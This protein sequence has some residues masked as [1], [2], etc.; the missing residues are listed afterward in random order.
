M[1]QE[2]W[3]MVDE[4]LFKLKKDIYKKT[5]DCLKNK[6]T[7]GYQRKLKFYLKEEI[8]QKKI[9]PWLNS[10]QIEPIQGILYINSIVILYD[11][12]IAVYFGENWKKNNQEI[13][14]LQEEDWINRTIFTQEKTRKRQFQN[15][16]TLCNKKR[17]EI[18]LFPAFSFGNNELLY[19]H[20]KIKNF[21][22]PD[23]FLTSPG[24]LWKN[25]NNIFIRQENLFD[26]MKKFKK[27]FEKNYQI[28]IKS[29]KYAE[30]L[31]LNP[32]R[33]ATKYK[34]PNLFYIYDNRNINEPGGIAFVARFKDNLGKT[35]IHKILKKL[36]YYICDFILTPILIAESEF[37]QQ[38]LKE[39]SGEIPYARRFFREIVDEKKM[40][41]RIPLVYNIKN[42][43]I[44]SDPFGN[45]AK[46]IRKHLNKFFA[47][48][49]GP[50]GKAMRDYR[51]FSEE[52]FLTTIKLWD[53]LNI[54]NELVGHYPTNNIKTMPIKTI[55]QFKKLSGER[56]NNPLL[57]DILYTA[58]NFE[59]ALKYISSYRE[60][61]IHCF[62]TFCFGFWLLCLKRLNGK[63]LFAPDFPERL[64]LLKSWFLTAIFH[65]IGIP[66]QKAGNYLQTL[67]EKLAYQKDLPLFSKWSKLMDNPHFHEI[68]FT[69]QFTKLGQGGIFKAKNENASQ[70]L[71][72]LNHTIVKLFLENATHPVLGGL[73]IYDFMKKNPSIYIDSEKLFPHVI[74][75]IFVHHIWDKEWEETLAQNWTFFNFDKHPLVYLLILCDTISQLERRFEDPSPKEESPVIRLYNLNEP[76]ED[77]NDY[78]VCSLLY[79]EK[80]TTKMEYYKKY[81]SEPHN[82]ISNGKNPILE[83]NLYNNLKHPTLCSHWIFYT[84]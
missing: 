82:L 30:A 63:F 16:L 22:I 68:L 42:L 10:K 3:N 79:G 57:I 50:S 52:I 69:D 11:G 13:K 61:F 64:I 41:T 29:D 8:L 18:P 1:G 70:A 73:I 49:I 39:K 46:L 59:P 56:Q 72:K 43:H 19:D 40:E 81:F 20:I 38:N 44:A 55:D 25:R 32:L 2:G 37:L 75:P 60:H 33:I 5:K 65:D 17:K 24:E 83:V 58:L 74:M 28:E 76:S 66:I 47:N 15:I 34:A 14:N 67:V 77:Q 54:T 62:H 4:E 31:L 6:D 12:R 71:I 45:K 23:K 7:E 27:E 9:A 80:S 51:V 36:Q 21:K 35:Q 78:A 84:P 26:T 53:D 48:A